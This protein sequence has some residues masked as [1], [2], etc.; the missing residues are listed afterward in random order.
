[1]PL[2]AFATD[3][4]GTLAHDGR[5]D[6]ATL[7]SLEAVQRRGATLVL[8][9][10]RELDDL[11]R[12]FPEHHMFDRVVAE[13]GG[14]LARGTDVRPLGPAPA[15]ALIEALRARDVRPLSV[16]RVI[17]ATRDPHGPTVREAIA[18][19]G[20]AWEISLNKGAVMVLPRGVTKATGLARALDDM[21]LDPCDVAAIGDAEN[22]LP[23]MAACGLG[24]AV[25]NALPEVKARADLVTQG[26]RGAGVREVLDA[27][28]AG[29]LPEPRRAARQPRSTGA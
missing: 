13:N 1:M 18:T 14:V 25:A 20:L 11:T 17:V 21:G 22:D 4:D 19:L 12:A 24:I 29:T 28:L 2:R 7:A 26:A 9:T 16:G 3:Y 23:M 5:V 27:W 15:P 8:V 10:G 6:E